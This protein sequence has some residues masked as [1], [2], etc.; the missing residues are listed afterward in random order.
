ME[1]NYYITPE[2]YDLAEKNGIC[3]AT[4]ESRIKQ[5]GWS[6]KKAITKR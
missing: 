1:V 2:E 5:L 4:L 3:K 6:K